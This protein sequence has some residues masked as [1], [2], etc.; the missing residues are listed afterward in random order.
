MQVVVGEDEGVRAGD[1][2]HERVGALLDGGR[3]GEV[4]G[5]RDRSRLRVPGG[6]GGEVGERDR[7]AV[8]GGAEGARRIKSLECQAA[9]TSHRRAATSIFAIWSQMR[10]SASSASLVSSASG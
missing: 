1:V 7:R 3:G 8:L 4:R 10:L 5:D 2:D 6:Q 9:S